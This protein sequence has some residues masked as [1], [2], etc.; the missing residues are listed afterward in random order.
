MHRRPWPLHPSPRCDARTRSDSPCRSSAVMGRRRCRMHGGATGGG[1]LGF[2]HAMR[3]LL[4]ENAEK[5]E[6]V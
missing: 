6:L 1:A 4:R 3:E 2:R 5:L